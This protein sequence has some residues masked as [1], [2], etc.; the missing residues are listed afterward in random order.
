MQSRNQMEQ[1]RWAP[2]FSST[3]HNTVCCTVVIKYSTVLLTSNKLIY[4]AILLLHAIIVTPYDSCCIIAH[5][6]Y[7]TD[8]YAKS[9]SENA[10]NFCHD[11]ILTCEAIEATGESWTVSVIVMYI[12]H[13]IM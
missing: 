6:L 7:Y 5:T 2:F 10:T 13:I 1:C 4:G 12:R 9:I 3:R 11:T 8:I